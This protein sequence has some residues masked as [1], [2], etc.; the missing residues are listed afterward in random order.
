MI[1]GVVGRISKQGLGQGI[2]DHLLGNWA[3]NKIEKA[4]SSGF[5]R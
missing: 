3:K 2:E 4:A 5:K 1:M